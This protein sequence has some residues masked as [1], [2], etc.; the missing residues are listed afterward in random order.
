M[1]SLAFNSV[2]ATKFSPSAAALRRQLSHLRL[3]CRLS[4]FSSP[5]FSGVRAKVTTTEQ[6]AVNVEAPVVVVTG[7]SRGIGKAVALAFGKAG[8]KVLVN[9]ARSSKEAEEV[10]KEAF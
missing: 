3:Q 10:S 5:A 2:A 9:Y 6:V 7:A 1:A 4:S 8:C